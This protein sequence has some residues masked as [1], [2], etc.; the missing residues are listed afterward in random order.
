MLGGDLAEDPLDNEEQL[1][2]QMDALPYMCRL[3]YSRSAAT[4]TRFFDPLT[5]TLSSCLQAGACYTHP[6]TLLKCTLGAWS[7]RTGRDGVWTAF[8]FSS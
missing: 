4:L 3:Q 6:Q 8:Y 7:V 5:A 1:G 2:D